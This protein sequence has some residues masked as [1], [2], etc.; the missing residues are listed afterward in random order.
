MEEQLL[1]QALH[2]RPLVVVVD[3]ERLLE[4]QLLVRCQ[5]VC[6]DILVI[7][8]LLCILTCTGSR[9]STWDHRTGN[10]NNNHFTHQDMLLEV[11]VKEDLEDLLGLTPTNHQLVPLGRQEQQLPKERRMNL[12]LD[13]KERR[14]LLLKRVAERRR[15]QRKKRKRRRNRKS[16]KRLLVHRNHFH[17]REE[18]I[19]QNKPTLDSFLINN[20]L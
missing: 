9:R 17:S 11:L 18:V 15:L 3:L 4:H 20:V 5:V 13:Q 7:L 14:S 10:S 2:L 8:I 16:Q 1:L 12:M 19:E 6:P